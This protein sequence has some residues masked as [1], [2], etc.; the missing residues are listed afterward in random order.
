M[1]IYTRKQFMKL[2]EGTIFSSG[3]PY[4]FSGIYIKGET[5]DVDFVESSLID[6]ESFSSE[7]NV[8]RMCEMEENGA[9]YP[10]NKDYGREGLFDDDML[11]MVYEKEDLEYVIQQMKNSCD[12]CQLKD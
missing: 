3:E 9:S 2:P 12:K 7:D 5:L 6:I 4:A 1:K 10:I 11:Y 8:D